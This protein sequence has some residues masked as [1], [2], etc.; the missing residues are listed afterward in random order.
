MAPS[1]NIE[2]LAF[3]VV[4]V[5]ISGNAAPGLAETGPR[6]SLPYRMQFC[7]DARADES[8]TNIQLRRNYVPNGSPAW[9]PPRNGLVGVLLTFL[10]VADRTAFSAKLPISFPGGLGSFVVG[11]SCALGATPVILQT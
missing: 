10:A 4:L 3:D 5:L 11:A 6:P 9:T 7:E 8:Q 1:T 2:P